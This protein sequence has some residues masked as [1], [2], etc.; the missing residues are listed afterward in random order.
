MKTN[1]RLNIACLLVIAVSTSYTFIQSTPPSFTVSLKQIQINHYLPG[2][3]SFAW[4]VEGNKLL[5]IGGRTEGYHG[6]P[7]DVTT[8]T[9]KK[10][11][12]SIFVINLA[13]YTYQALA[14]NTKDSTFFQFSST[15][16]EFKQAGDTLYLAG[17][18]GVNDTVS[19]QS[20]YT[21]NKIMAISV[22]GMI[23]QVG[24]QNQGNPA[25]AITG[26]A[27]SPF[28]AVTGGE[29]FEQNGVF[30]LMF[31]Q[32]YA[33]KYTITN[34]GKYTC[35]VRRFRFNNNT[36]S[37]TSSLIDTN[38]HRRDLNAVPIMQNGGWLYAGYGGVFT[39][40]LSSYNNPVYISAGTGKINL[41]TDTLTQV[42]NQY[43]CAKAFI[44]DPASNANFTILF[45]GIGKYQ[46]HANTGK[47]ENGDNG[48]MLPFVS[49]IT[50]LIYR[51]GR[52]R[53]KIQLPPGQP[54]MPGLIGTDAIFIP[55]SSLLLADHT[56]DFS[57][58]RAGATPIGIIYGGIRSIM[59]TSSGP[60]PTSLNQSLYTVYLTPNNLKKSKHK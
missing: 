23:K 41:T 56:I 3:Q 51:N 44:Y 9:V 33:G 55:D 58:I 27:T 32:N 25:R 37:D 38:L 48:A 24:L 16:M 43:E 40:V 5:L 10:A 2:L 18:F 34:T 53:Q 17:G 50:Q 7:S 45:G 1:I 31:G 21:F 28:L 39:P 35:A 15:N 12:D 29:L 4:A 26:S 30:Y 47:W 54:A 60:Y 59:P 13:D 8:F 42:T 52:T 49:S 20:N 57:K 6:L 36:I 14:L 19:I 46:Y 22:S 11:N